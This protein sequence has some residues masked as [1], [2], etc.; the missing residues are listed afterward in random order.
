MTKG[1][2][3]LNYAI[4]VV[5]F[6]MSLNHSNMHFFLSVCYHAGGE[7]QQVVASD[8]TG[9]TIDCHVIPEVPQ[10]LLTIEECK[11]AFATAPEL[12]LATEG[13]MKKYLEKVRGSPE[14]IRVIGG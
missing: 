9:A 6:G 7:D 13:D 11:T 10:G 4:S 3:Q 8:T 14:G 12:G 5:G 1:Y 2:K